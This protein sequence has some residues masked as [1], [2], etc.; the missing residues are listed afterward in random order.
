MSQPLGPLWGVVEVSSYLGVPVE[1]LYTWRKNRTGPPA[2]RVGKH[3]RY[4]P[5]DVR[6]WFRQ[7]TAA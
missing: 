4:E 2:G 3:L 1:T 6:T 5:D 7:K